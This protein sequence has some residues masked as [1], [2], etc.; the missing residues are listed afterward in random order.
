MRKVYISIADLIKSIF[1]N[2]RMSN[3]K[4]PICFESSD[5]NNIEVL[6]PVKNIRQ[7]FNELG[8]SFLN[9]KTFVF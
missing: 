5:T 9:N 2:L 6:V 1:S 3:K 4:H 8:T 7:T